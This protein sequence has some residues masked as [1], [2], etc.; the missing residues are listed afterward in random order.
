MNDGLCFSII[1]MQSSKESNGQWIAS[2]ML[3]LS[4][5]RNSQLDGLVKR[6]EPH[7]CSRVGAKRRLDQFLRFPCYLRNVFSKFGI[8][9]AP[10]MVLC[11]VTMYKFVIVIKLNIKLSTV[12]T[13]VGP[14]PKPLN[15]G[16]STR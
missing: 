4:R 15:I 13:V 1:F 6:I 9:G 7:L 3:M 8:L 14:F 16:I 12:Q 2:H 5:P 10:M 11:R